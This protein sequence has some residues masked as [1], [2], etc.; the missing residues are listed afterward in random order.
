MP[1]LLRL[2]VLTCL[3]AACQNGPTATPPLVTVTGAAGTPVASAPAVTPPPG[4]P[5]PGEDQTPTAP[6]LLRL[7]LPPEFTPDVNT[8]GGRVLAAQLQAFEQAHP[9]IAV[10]IRTKAAGGVGGLLNALVTAANVAPSGLPDIVA[11]RRDDL[12]QAAEAGLVAALEPYVPAETLADFY[13]F[14]QSLGRVNGGWMGL[15]FA[16]DARVLAYTTTLYPNPPAEWSEVDAGIYLLPGAEPTA[17]TLL[18]A[19]L[20]LGGTLTDEAGATHLDTSLLAAALEEYQD[21]ESVGRLPLTTLD[22]VDPAAT[23]QAF[24]ERRAA[25]VATSAQ[26]FL[27]EQ[28]HVTGAAMTLLPTA[29]QP[30]L[31]L[32]DGWSW[33]L[34]NAASGQQPLAAELLNFLLA[35]EQHAAWTEAGAV[36]P[37]RA[38]TLAGWQSGRLAAQVSSVLTAAQMQPSGAL[39]GVVGPALR[40]ALADVISGRATP[41]AAATVA[42][43]AVTV[44]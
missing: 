12:G 30:G 36:L 1:R 18:T 21:L 41:F 23:W 2:L 3:L 42:A 31:A 26:W 34:V 27:A 44:P 39:L 28:G 11:L 20:V 25:L 10:E 40:Q 13:P 38:A 9:G 17:L 8:P 29:G 24:R 33:A 37:T 7:W 15:P 32:T 43:E 35:P 19:Y 6:G 16:A 4:T 14:A 22:Y 5:A